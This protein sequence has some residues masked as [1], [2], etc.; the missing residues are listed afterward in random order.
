MCSVHNILLPTKPTYFLE[1]EALT[2]KEAII[3]Q[4][5]SKK[6]IVVC[7]GIDEKIL[8][9]LKS[10]VPKVN[11]VPIGPHPCGS[12]E[13]KKI[14]ELSSLKKPYKLEKKTFLLHL[15]YL[16]AHS[17]SSN[18]VPSIHRT[19]LIDPSTHGNYSRR[20]IM[21]KKCGYSDLY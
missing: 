8:P 17:L 7:D 20:I 11:R 16:L 4:V 3:E 19:S 13:V 1:K 2:F 18:K 10:P 5:K 12:Y 6:F 9:S 21:L 14:A 15:T